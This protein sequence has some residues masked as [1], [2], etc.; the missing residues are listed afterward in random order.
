MLAGGGHKNG[1]PKRVVDQIKAVTQLTFK[2][3]P[4][5]RTRFAGAAKGRQFLDS[6]GR[7]NANLSKD[8]VFKIPKEARRLIST[9][10]EPHMEAEVIE[11]LSP[12]VD[13]PEEAA[14]EHV[15]NGGSLMILGAPGV[16]KS[17]YAQQLVKKRG[18]ERREEAS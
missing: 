15:L 5:L 17:H 12:W 4:E 13:L 9:H 8:P 3:L 10:S 1:Y 18:M 14:V 2:E 11:P 7:I 16:G 6:I